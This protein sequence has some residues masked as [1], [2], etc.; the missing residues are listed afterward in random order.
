MHM[1][2][3]NKFLIIGNN[4]REAI[5]ARRLAEDSVVYAA[6]AKK[7]PTILDYVRQTG[8]KLLPDENITP[9]IIVD[10]ARA[11]KID[12]V[13]ISAEAPLA[14]G[15]IDALVN[16]NIPAVGGSRAAT[17]LEWDKAYALNLVNEELPALT[18]YYKIARTPAEIKNCLH[19]A[20]ARQQE[21]VVKPLGLTGGKGVKVMP[22]HLPTYAAAQLYAQEIYQR[23][24]Q[25][26]LVEKLHG[27]EFT[28][29]G[30]CDGKTMV[31]APPT[32]DYPYRYVNDQ[33]P[34]TGGMGCWTTPK[35]D[36]P[37]L[38]PAELRV[39]Q[40]ALRTIM[41]K[42]RQQNTPLQGVL[43]GGFFQTPDGIR[44]ME[45]NCRL[46]DPEAIN[47]LSIMK[48][49][50]SNLIKA[51]WRRELSEN[52]I[53][54]A[55][56]ASVVK[57]LVAPEYPNDSSETLEFSLDWEQIKKSNVN[58]YCGS[59]Q[60]SARGYIA[61]KRSRVCAL[62]AVRA[63]VKKASEDINT[64]YHKHVAGNLD[65]R[66]DIGEEAPGNFTG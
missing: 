53:A 39:C 31:F 41:Q 46:G 12:Y 63:T 23:E 45:F 55:P 13:F 18:P 30:F 4:A 20:A 66:E 56:Q 32:Y 48:G 10:F 3:D 24:H 43:T 54:W 21:I 51:L 58:V 17:R 47:V 50:F 8:G 59:A 27:K 19:E 62:T 40:E 22:V 35:G 14:Q 37:F 49:S 5:I 38:S 26:L 65:L 57:Y 7:N 2:A 11:E 28:L 29:T 1:P 61:S 6:G 52:S 60:K 25:V 36:L 33:G 42:L 34:G 64:V 16:N 15:V 9:A 44:F